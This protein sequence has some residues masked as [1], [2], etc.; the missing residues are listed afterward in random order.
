[1]YLCT[2]K[3]REKKTENVPKFS[4]NENNSPILTKNILILRKFSVFFS[5]FSYD[6]CSI[7]QVKGH[8]LKIL[9]LDIFKSNKNH[10]NFDDY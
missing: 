3:N 1:M 8:I 6:F 2:D 9:S 7:Q 5:K 10:F 4:K